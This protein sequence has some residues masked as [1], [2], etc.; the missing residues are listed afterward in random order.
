MKNLEDQSRNPLSDVTRKFQR[1]PLIFRATFLGIL[2]SSVGVYSWLFVVALVPAPW[3]LGIMGILLWLYIKYFTGSWWP[4]STAEIR[5][6][7]F[8]ATKL[9]VGIMKWGLISALLIVIIWQSSII[10]TFRIFD[11][12]GDKLTAGYD[13]T[14]MPLWV[15]WL[16]IIM[17]SLV[18]GICEETGYRGYMQSPLESQYGPGASITLV[19]ILFLVIH[20]QQVWAPPLLIHLFALSVLLGILAYA[21]DSLIPGIIAHFFLD[22][23]NFSFWWTDLAGRYNQPLITQAGVDAH[24]LAWSMIFVV[25]VGLFFWTIQKTIRVGPQSLIYTSSINE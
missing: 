14:G 3:S 8:R 13:L 23:I 7:K 4:K 2:V 5:Q 17:S 19:S 10:V 12:P 1:I 16:M 22:I 9:S 25:S 18:A 15:A 20:L 24:F 11:F 21:S 6:K